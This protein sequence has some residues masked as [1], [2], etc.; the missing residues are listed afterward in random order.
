MAYQISCYFVGS[1]RRAVDDKLLLHSLNRQKA[2]VRVTAPAILKPSLRP[3]CSGM[4]V[5]LKLV[6]LSLRRCS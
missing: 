3:L 6:R 5:G 1:S 4:K 2:G